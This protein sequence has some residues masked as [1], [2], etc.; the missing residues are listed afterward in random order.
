M[1]LVQE[2]VGREAGHE[3]IREHAVASA[4]AMREEGQPRNDLVDRLAADP[5]I[6]VDRAVMES[7]LADPFSLTGLAS[8]QVTVF[9]KKVVRLERQHQEAAAYV[10]GSIL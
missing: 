2:G 7:A 9:C 5:R 10:P 6:V 4:L 1:N 3:A 8:D